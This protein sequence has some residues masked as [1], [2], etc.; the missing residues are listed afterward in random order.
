MIPLAEVYP[1]L[2][3]RY[4]DIPEVQQG[5]VR[6]A[7]NYCVGE[8]IRKISTPINCADGILLVR[9]QDTQWQATLGG[10]KQEILGKINKYLKKRL[11]QDL[12]V[13]VG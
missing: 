4:A 9:V 12:R 6:L 7:W 10:M 2:V 5:L 13:E 8:K 1:V 3:E 11:V